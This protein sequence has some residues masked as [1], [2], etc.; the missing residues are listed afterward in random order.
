MAEKSL[1]GCFRGYFRAKSSDWQ[2]GEG[3]GAQTKALSEQHR[4]SHPVSLGFAV[5][6]YGYGEAGSGVD[7]GCVGGGDA[8]E[9][10]IRG[11]I[12]CCEPPLGCGVAGQH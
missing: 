5:P 8:G 11:I 12:A 1:L 7:I 6:S 10:T 3:F 4:R 9:D 2:A